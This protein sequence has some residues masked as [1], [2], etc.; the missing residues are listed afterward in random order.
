MDDV[1]ALAFVYRCL[2][3]LRRELNLFGDERDAG[4]FFF[5]LNAVALWELK[6]TICHEPP[7]S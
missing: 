2:Q 4:V 6:I 7:T 5:R 3:R 1:P